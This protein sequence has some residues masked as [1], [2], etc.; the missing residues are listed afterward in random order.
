MASTISPAIPLVLRRSRPHKL[1]TGSCLGSWSSYLDLW[2]VSPTHR[3]AFSA[4]SQRGSAYWLILL[5]DKSTLS[6][7]L[8]GCRECIPS[9]ENE[10]ERLSLNLQLTFPSI[11]M[12]YLCGGKQKECGRAPVL[13]LFGKLYESERV[14][15]S[16]QGRIALSRYDVWALRVIAI[17]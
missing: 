12:D 4:E 7:S 6:D 9:S 11:S 14:P 13:L 1:T 10:Q 2:S 5:Q 15:P 16:Y 8:W 17:P 3:D